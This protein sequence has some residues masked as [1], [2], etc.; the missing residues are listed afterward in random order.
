MALSIIKNGKICTYGPPFAS[1]MA[2]Q[3]KR[4]ESDLMFPP[5]R[6]CADRFRCKMFYNHETEKWSCERKDCPGRTDED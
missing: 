5:D 6:G 1:S 2:E 4:P 3:R